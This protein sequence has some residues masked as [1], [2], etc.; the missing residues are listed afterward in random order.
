MFVAVA[1]AINKRVPAVYGQPASEPE[2]ETE[3][4]SV[5]RSEHDSHSQSPSESEFQ[6]D[7]QAGAG[8]GIAKVCNII[9]SRQQTLPGILLMRPG[10]CCKGIKCCNDATCLLGGHS[11]QASLM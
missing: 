9:K 6:L 3:T 7:S 1:T 5:P 2:P 4:A 8:P 11:G 10:Q